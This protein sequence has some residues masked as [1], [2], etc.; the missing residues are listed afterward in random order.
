MAI[1]AVAIVVPLIGITADV[2]DVAFRFRALALSATILGAL[3][4]LVRLWAHGGSVYL[5]GFGKMLGLAAALLA[6]YAGAL[7]LL[8]P[9]VFPGVVATK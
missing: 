4:A 3:A 8:L 2:G 5:D 7:L 9:L 6:V 1:L